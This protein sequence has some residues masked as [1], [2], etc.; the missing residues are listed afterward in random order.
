[1]GDK[2]LIKPLEYLEPNE[3]YTEE[4][5][6]VLKSSY[7]ENKKEFF[8]SIYVYL[9][10]DKIFSQFLL[11]VLGEEGYYSETAIFTYHLLNTLFPKSSISAKNFEYA[12]N[13]YKKITKDKVV[14]SKKENLENLL[15]D[16]N[17]LAEIN[18]D[19]EEEFNFYK[20]LN[21]EIVGNKK[22]LKE[23]F[24]SLENEESYYFFIM[25]KSAR[26]IEF[27]LYKHFQIGKLVTEISLYDAIDYIFDIEAK[28][29][30]KSISE[31]QVKKML[32]SNEAM[33]FFNYTV[34]KS[35]FVFVTYEKYL[36]DRIN[37]ERL[38]YFKNSGKNKTK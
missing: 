33:N 2:S 37:K 32:S 21:F 28:N 10:E 6:K 19:L 25:E 35:F 1:M 12:V 5:I 29:S 23:K 13:K 31:N 9:V 30:Y 20:R 8:D 24:K 22:E 16:E 7:F 38:E 15:K 27:M 3:K 17:F 34:N 4:I 14:Y 36:F 11:K 18:N 26:L